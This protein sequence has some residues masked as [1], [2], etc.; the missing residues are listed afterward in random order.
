MTDAALEAA[1]FAD[2]GTQQGHRRQAEPDWASIHRE[3]KRKHVTL[4][5]LWDEYIRAIRRAIAIRASA[6]CTAAGKAAVG[7]DAAGPHGRRQAVRRLRRRTVPV[8]VDRLTGESAGADFRRGH[9]RVEL[10]LCRGDLDPG[11]C[12]LDR[13]AHAR[14]R[15]HRRRAALLVPDNTKVAVIKACLY[16]PQVNR[17]YAEMA[18]HYG[19]AICRH[20]RAAAGQG[21]CF[22]LHLILVWRG[23]GDE[24]CRAS[25]PPAA[26]LEDGLA[27][28]ISH[29]PRFRLSIALLDQPWRPHWWTAVSETPKRR[30]DLA[31]GEH[32]AAAQPLVAAW[33]ACRRCG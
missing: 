9:G 14:L 4:T 31:R 13:R 22:I 10:H 21:D 24:P 28:G 20:G 1:L 33:A 25:A 12:R 8:M 7:D 5:M 6:S 30:G 32:A 2:P 11:A 26:A 27:G 16:E 23:D 17:T 3:L 19:T 29:R 15:G 18:A